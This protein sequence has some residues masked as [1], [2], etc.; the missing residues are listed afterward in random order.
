MSEEERRVF[1]FLS[2]SVFFLVE[3][4]EGEGEEKARGCDSDEKNSF[5]EVHAE[6]KDD[7]SRS[8]SRE[9]A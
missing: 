2:T 4:E 8:E 7:I 9:G 3:V 1:F 6:S 5:A